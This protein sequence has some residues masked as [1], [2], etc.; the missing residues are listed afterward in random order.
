MS[1]KQSRISYEPFARSCIH[2][3]KPACSCACPLNL[4]IPEIVKHIQANNFTAA[5]RLYQSQSVFPGIVSR[6]CNEPCRDACVRGE[7]DRSV[8]LKLLEKACVDITGKAEPARYN[9]PGKN[10][11]IAIIG[12]GPAGLACAVKLAAKNYAVTVYERNARIGGRFSQL[13]DPGVF[14]PEIDLQFGNTGCEFI[15]ETC[16]DGLE[17][18][19]YDALLVA[20]G[21]GGNDFGL[22]KGLNHQSYGT[23][24]PGI[25]MAGNVTGATT[26]V[27]DI[28]H[29]IV[30]AHSIEKYI[31][32]GLMDGIP[33][34]FPTA[35]SEL[36]MDLSRVPVQE[37]VLPDNGDRYRREEAEAEAA[38]CLR[39]D[40]SACSDCCE[41]FG[42]FR[43]MPKTL[44][45]DTIASLH[46]KTSFTGQK[47]TRAMA[48][49]N[50]CG[51]C[52]EVCPQDI[53][54]GRF[55]HDFRHFK[56]EDGMFPPAF[57][58][59]FM[60]DMYFSNED[61]W[62]AETAPGF[63]SAG[64]L[65]FPGCQLGA[66]DPLYVEQTYKLLR[67]RIRDLALIL[68][69]CGAPADWAAEKTVHGMVIDKLRKNWEQ[70]G[71]PVLIFACPT[72]KHQLAM[73]MP[74]ARGVSLYSILCEE[75][76]ADNLPEVNIDACVFDPCSSRYDP[77]MQESVRKIAANAGIRLTELHYSRETAQCCSWGGHI[78]PANPSAAE[79]MV[80][81][82]AAAS[83]NPYITYCTNCRDTFADKGKTC[84][85][86]LDLVLGLD[87]NEYDPPS[88]SRRRRNRLAARTSLLKDIWEAEM[89]ET[90][91]DSVKLNV[92]IPEELIRKM[93]E[94]LIL[95][96][97]VYR[98]V[99]YCEES[100]NKLLDNES[101]SYAGHLRIGLITYWV[102]YTRD[103][104]I[105]SLKNVYTHRVRILENETGAVGD[106]AN[107]SEV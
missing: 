99:E 33:E 31:K 73:Y 55:F 77:S 63:D 12:S 20:T 26:A 95:E 35:E 65:F 23:V 47:A 52:A 15:L 105:Y 7:L 91:D 56:A 29:G 76:L 57:H 9:L 62:L 18:I 69:C 61:A 84:Y 49:C 50:L 42:H 13:L 85:H 39:C 96:E 27:D 48:A 21:N 19:E 106:P 1:D 97:D 14:L 107:K 89:A 88:L 75:G 67:T 60:R 25:F 90:E 2:G 22:L 104:E 38:R 78:K 70:M 46:T 45:A 4:D 37:A 74:E 43:K 24:Q 59:F 94:M 103:K 51:L 54:M 100:G 98:T 6:I 17:H 87:K 66:S 3:K 81:N 11:K 41:L 82:R 86:I 36:V 28:A 16:I 40:C 44:V 10:K 83:G 92:D 79:K 68:G 32:T 58:D 53:D 71:R 5:Y 101:G 102:E 72:C 34:T 64:Y 30:A 93:N 8:S 80:R